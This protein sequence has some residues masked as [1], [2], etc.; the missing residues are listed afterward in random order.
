MIREVAPA[1]VNLILEVGRRRGDGL[2]E[3]CSLFASL[4]LADGLEVTTLAEAAGGD[5]VDCPG[6]EGPNLVSA[7]LAEY[8]AASGPDGLSPLRV[9]V[10]K[11][12]P[13]AA[14]LGGGSADAAAALRAAD[15]LATRRL[16][17]TRL[18][19]VGMRVGADV[20][21]QIDP[22]HALVA[23]AG[24]RV[25]RVELP[26]LPVVLV[27]QSE[28]LATARVYAELDRRGE[29]RPRLEPERLRHL[30]ASK[31][32]DDLLDA[33]GNDLEPAAVALRPE[34]GHAME[35]LR[36]A[37][38]RA[39]LVS[40]SGPTV[41]GVFETEASARAAGARI[42]GAIVTRLRSPEGGLASAA[43]AVA[44]QRPARAGSAR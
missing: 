41:V 19:E 20:P 21:S 2:H 38:A 44:S 3:I 39:V 23:G 12:I 33:M 26:P 17:R 8:R 5:E 43:R 18:R 29:G 16:E 22:G 6:V 36:G 42:A 32:V 4:E 35:E 25:E 40:G 30:L 1:K 31:R 10:E 24:E 11:G 28:G 9:R 14:G 15:A 13:V 27:P 37:G 34:L 7:A